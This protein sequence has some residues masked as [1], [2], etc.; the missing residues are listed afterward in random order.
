MHKALLLIC[1]VACTLLST[2]QFLEN[3]GQVVDLNQNFHPEVEYYTGVGNASVF[4]EKD[5]V[6]FNFREKEEFDFSQPKYQNN[7]DLRDSIKSTLGS[8][9]H[10][11]DLQLIGTNSEVEIRGEEK[12]YYVCLFAFPLSSTSNCGH[13]GCG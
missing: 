12:S 10:R 9:F 2:A 4:F 8:T 6:V 5:K 7:K 11:L 3:K 1:A 13:S